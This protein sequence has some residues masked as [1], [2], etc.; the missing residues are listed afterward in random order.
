MVSCEADTVF[1]RKGRGE[2]V[3]ETNRAGDSTV[4]GDTKPSQ[5]E[6][7]GEREK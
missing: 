4:R 3:T 5:A 2:M 7:N 6:D 1:K